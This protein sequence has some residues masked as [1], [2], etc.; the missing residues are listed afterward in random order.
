MERAVRSP[1]AARMKRAKQST[2]SCS[3]RSSKADLEN[4]PP[5]GAKAR[6]GGCNPPKAPLPPRKYQ[7][8]CIVRNRYVLKTVYRDSHASAAPGRRR[9]SDGR[10]NEEIYEQ[11]QISCVSRY[12]RNLPDGD[13]SQPESAGERS[14]KRWTGPRLSVR[15]L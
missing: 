8:D 7:K 2:M 12:C 10:D 15:L 4:K 9:P 5:D 3:T 14:S 11:T 13:R 6:T 1:T